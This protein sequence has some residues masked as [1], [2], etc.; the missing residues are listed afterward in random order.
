[1]NNIDFA[2]ALIDY[3]KQT[4]MLSIEKGKKWYCID[5]HDYGVISKYIESF[6]HYLHYL[7]EHQ[8]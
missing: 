7:L 8:E 4:Y 2:K 5:N 6:S 3:A 1:M